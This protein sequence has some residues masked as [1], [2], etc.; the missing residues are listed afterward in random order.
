MDV[1]EISSGLRLCDDGIWHSLESQSVSYPSDRNES[2]FAVE[3]A[4]F[5]F[6][7]RNQ[8]VVS[9][10][11][12]FP[13]PKNGTIFDIGG[14]NGFVSVGLLEAGFDVTLVEPG[15]VGAAHAR[16]RGIRNVVCATI[17]TAKFRECSLPAVGLFDVIEH[18]DDDTAFLKSIRVIMKAG[19]LLYATVPAFPSLWS[20]ED[21]LV[22]HFRRYTLRGIG[23]KLKASGF[24]TVFSSYIFRLL[25]VPVFLLRTLPSKVGLLRRRGA[26]ATLSRD[27]AVESGL[28][29]RILHVVLKSE[30]DN[31]R[32]KRPMR[33]GSSCMI[34]AT[35]L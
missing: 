8:C 10:V 20:E 28:F 9:V 22:G 24:Q 33:F 17:E 35:R 19:G 3:D 7:H 32:N 23:D 34:V 12:C 18:I 26:L 31:L 13:P 29:S 6:R 25:P 4:S 15:L 5:W 21:A 1:Q 16:K 27:H 11:N 30:V 2:C 14:G